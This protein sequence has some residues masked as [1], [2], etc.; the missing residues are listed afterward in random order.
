MI[1]NS[2]PEL[3]STTLKTW[4][5][6][7]P[8]SFGKVNM[9]SPFVHHVRAGELD[10]EVLFLA[11]DRP[12]DARK[13]LSLELTGAW[14]NEAREI[15]KAIV[16]A[17]T[18]RVGRYPSRMQGGAT[19]SGIIMDT[20]PPDNQ[21]WWYKASEEEELEGWKFFKQPS[22]TSDEAENLEN[23]PKN[24]YKRICVGKDEDWVKIYVHGTYGF[25]V[26]GKAVFPMFRDRLHIA[27]FP[28]EP[29]RGIPIL[30]GADFGLTPAAVLGQKLPD[31]RWIIF[32]EVVTEDCGI[33]RF[34]EFLA[35]YMGEH[36]PEFDVDIGFG[37]PAGNIR[38]QSDE[39][40]AIEIMG[41]H[42]P[43]K[44]KPAP[45]NNE[46]A[47][48]LEVVKA[49]LNRLIDGQPGLLI[50]P[51]CR[52]IRKGFAGGYHYKALR[53]GGGTQTHD[54]P[55]KNEWSHPAE[56]LQYLLLGG[57]EH[58]VVLGK[59]KRAKRRGEGPVIAK[60]KDY[61]IFGKK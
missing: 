27:E 53:T 31:G 59:T 40:T 32:D 8:L 22:G 15:P 34:A 21:S 44:W 36:Y 60:G 43:W 19:W 18:G 12:E 29:V 52:M 61:D 42:T 28:I 54:Y 55:N 6:W 10:M 1:R 50:S 16:D 17:L 5:E 9:D 20:N 14:L 46:F 39:R 30:I 49:A 38:A 13:L 47:M 11:L 7:C 25:L 2:Y 57:G 4:A 58:E 41:S 35:S 33:I 26:E 23:L 37:D 56:A 3:K 51:K 48:R 24:Y 45:G